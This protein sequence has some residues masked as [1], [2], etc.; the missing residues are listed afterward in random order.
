MTLNGIVALILRYVT[1]FVY[2]VVVKKFTFA[3]SSHDEFLCYLCQGDMF[4]SLLVR[5]LATLRKNVQ[6]D[7]HEIFREV[8]QWANEQ[9]IKFWCRSGSPSGYR[10]CFPD[11]SLLGDTESG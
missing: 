1:E 8:W 3:I 9:M 10:D 5:L 11:S 2:D 7:L 4:S 6:T